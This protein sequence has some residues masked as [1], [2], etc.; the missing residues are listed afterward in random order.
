MN[1]YKYFTFL[2]VI[3]LCMTIFPHIPLSANTPLSVFFIS[4]SVEGG[5][6]VTIKNISADRQGSWRIALLGE[7][8]EYF[9]INNQRADFEHINDHYV[10]LPHSLPVGSEWTFM[11]TAEGL[12]P[13]QHTVELA[14]WTTQGQ[15][16][17]PFNGALLGKTALFF[18]VE[19][20]EKEAEEDRKEEAVEEEGKE[21]GKEESKTE[22]APKITPEPEEE[23][24][25]PDVAMP[26]EVPQVPDLPNDKDDNVSVAPPQNNA[27]VPV[28]AQTASLPP[29]ALIHLPP[30][31]A[32][33]LAPNIV[34]PIEDSSQFQPQNTA[35]NPTNVALVEPPDEAINP[36]LSVAPPPALEKD[37]NSEDISSAEEAAEQSQPAQSVPNPQTANNRKIVSLMLS[38]VGFLFSVMAVVILRR[39]A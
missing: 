36:P 19:E 1:F 16:Q 15:P 34:T 10:Q 12:S 5:Q 3:L 35:S 18:M 20:P 29:P 24:V 30:P 37:E 31:Q 28:P 4:E 17:Y 22:E 14:L 23:P 33:P 11:L 21:E 26:E 25:Y 6:L 39:R 27:P 38:F 2:L 13:G 7:N 9:R 32:A 8:A